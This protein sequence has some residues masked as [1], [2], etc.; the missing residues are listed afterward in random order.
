MGLTMSA[1]GV[2]CDAAFRGVI[3]TCKALA[4]DAILSS[5]FKLKFRLTARPIWDYE[6]CALH[7]GGFR[8][9]QVVKIGA[10]CATP[11]QL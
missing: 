4:R 11:P 5:F 9:P 6:P 3:Y 7:V 2:Q 8:S 1:M 10:A